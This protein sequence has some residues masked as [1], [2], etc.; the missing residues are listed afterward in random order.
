MP[1]DA[2]FLSAV[3]QELQSACGARIDKIHQPERD[4]LVLLLRSAQGARRLLMTASPNRAR[5]HF[6]EASAENPQQPPMFCTVSYTHL[7]L[8]TTLGV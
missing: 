4:T 8:P 1:F 2:V 5:V 6:T 7:T 3:T